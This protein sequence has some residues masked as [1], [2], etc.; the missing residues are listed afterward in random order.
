MDGINSIRLRDFANCWWQ[1]YRK[2][3]IQC[4]RFECHLNPK[5]VLKL[6]EAYS[7]LESFSN[8]FGRNGSSKVDDEGGMFG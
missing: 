1:I 5:P 8:P 3:T 4:V 7:I 2:E 6:G